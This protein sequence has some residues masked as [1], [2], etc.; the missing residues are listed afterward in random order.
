MKLHYIQL[1][2]YVAVSYA[3]WRTSYSRVVLFVHL[4]F[5]GIN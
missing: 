5:S 3:V 1:L 2:C 4:S